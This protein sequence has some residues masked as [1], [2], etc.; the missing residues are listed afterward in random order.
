MSSIFDAQGK[1]HTLDLEFKPKGIEKKK[2]PEKFSASLNLLD[3]LDWELESVSYDGT[4]IYFGSQ[5]LEFSRTEGGAA[6]ALYSLIE[7]DLPNE[8]KLTVNF[9]THSSSEDSSVRLYPYSTSKTKS[10]LKISQQDGYQEGKQT[11]FFFDENGQISYNYDNKQVEEGIYVALAKFDDLENTLIQTTDNLFR[12][13][14]NYGRHIGRANKGGFGSI[15]PTK[16][17]TSNVDSTT[18]FG[19][20]VVLQRMFQACSQIME[21]DKQ[22]LEELFKK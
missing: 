1:A 4:A 6:N 3:G 13:K 22:L 15:I 21:I 9:G 18:E 2:D 14:N 20:I 17:E 12:S 7:L 16:L 5:S 19:N 11:S 8:Q 10:V